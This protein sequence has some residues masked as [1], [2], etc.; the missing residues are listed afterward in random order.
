MRLVVTVTQ[1]GAIY[2]G[3]TPRIVSEELAAAM[4]EATGL[5]EGEVKK[6]TPQGVF[7]ER[8][9]LRSTIYGEVQGKGTPLV[10]GV[11]AH[12]SKYGDVIE[13]GRRPGRKW[14][15]EGALIRWME[16]KLGMDESTAIKKEFVLRRK[17]GVK[18]FPGA[19]MFEG[20]LTDNWPRLQRIFDR[21]GFEIARRW[22][23]E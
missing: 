13:K 10:K 5:L 14:P 18:G 16:V 21:R 2:E 3:K 11:I 9:G 6:R 7:G 15:P 8:G 4:Y 22:E 12:Q 17:I 20:A 1:K 23:N 19:H